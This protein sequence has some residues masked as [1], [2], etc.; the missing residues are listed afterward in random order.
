L[1]SGEINLASFRTSGKQLFLPGEAELQESVNKEIDAWQFAFHGDWSKASA[2][3]LESAAILG[4]AGESTRGYRAF[5]LYISAIWLSKVDGTEATKASVRRILRDAR[6]AVRRGAWINEMFSLS[7]SD[8]G[9]NSPEDENAASSVAEQLARGRNPEKIKEEISK[10]IND[11][12]ETSHKIFEP[13]LSKLGVFLG[14]K[15]DK[16]DIIGGPDS[17]WRWGNYLWITHEAKTEELPNNTLPLQDIRQ[18]NS[19]LDLLSSVEQTDE[20]PTGSISTIIS[21]RAIVERSAAISARFP[22]HLVSPTEI[23]EIAQDVSQIWE[24]LLPFGAQT[25]IAKLKPKALEVLKNSGCLPS[26]IRDRLSQNPI[27][28]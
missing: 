14:A 5:Q 20:V 7:F 12:G 1:E 25:D 10:M 27:S 21:P 4:K 18:A 22:L 15:S 2:S 24:Q 9:A 8:D 6:G 3:L 11:L 16:P 28:L 19:H 17:A 13:A 26:Q 23:L